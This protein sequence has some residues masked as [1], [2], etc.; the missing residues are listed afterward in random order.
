MVFE[1]TPTGERGFEFSTR[2]KAEEEVRLRTLEG[3]LS[4]I[5][6]IQ[7]FDVGRRA[8]AVYVVGN[9]G[10][11]PA[12]V[13]MIDTIE[14]AREQAVDDLVQNYPDITAQVPPAGQILAKP[15]SVSLSLNKSVESVN[16][17]AIKEDVF[18]SAV[19][20]ERENVLE[21][22][23]I[24]HGPFTVEET[25]VMPKTGITN[26]IKNLS[27]KQKVAGLGILGAVLFL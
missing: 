10:P 16:P 5:R 7:I 15:E 20:N 17:L 9:L 25:G 13:V 23:W 6:A 12:E 24:R 4:S 8:T 1:F 27:T 21:D 18:N 26:T 22:P 3:A 2:A 14:N 11:I 19:V